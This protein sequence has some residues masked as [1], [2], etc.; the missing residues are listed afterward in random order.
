MIKIVIK[1]AFILAIST[2][3]V[4]CA[5]NYSNVDPE[6]KN[7]PFRL[8]LDAEEGGDLPDADEYG[9]EIK[10]ADYL[11]ELP[12]QPIIIHFEIKD[13]SLPV[14]IDKV[15]YE[16]EEDDC[17]FER[18]LDFLYDENSGTGTI[19][20]AVDTDLE[21][22]PEEFEIVFTLPEEV[23][24]FV[25]EITSLES[26]S[27]TILGAPFV[28]EY[29][30]LDNDLAGEWILAITS[31]EEF[32]KFKSAFAPISADLSEISFVDITGEVILE[33]G[34]EEMKIEIVLLEEEEVTECEDGETETSI[35]NKI[36]EIEAEYEVE[37][38]ELILEGSHFII[39]DD[40]EIEDELD[41][42]LEAEYTLNDDGTANLKLL[43]LIDEDNYEEG[44]ELF[45][46]EVEFE[47]EKD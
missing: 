7:Y 32:E 42:I 35:E 38:G 17:V 20:L 6:D 33:F 41:F 47:I 39:G 9:L 2:L 25:F 16:F 10:F 14:D 37:D 8:I 4:A 15:V 19:A 5:D 1:Y 21:T 46:E 29:A 40:G 22:L 36:I 13:A 43:K 34:F 11:G 3:M 26:S 31:E 24:E 18:E 44:E 30:S 23:V 12:N 28:F 45:S 27:N